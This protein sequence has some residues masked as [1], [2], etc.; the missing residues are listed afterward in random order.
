MD[1]QGRGMEQKYCPSPGYY[2]EN[3][4]LECPQ[5]C[6]DGYSD[7]LEG[8]CLACKPGLIG[9][10][11][12]ECAAGLYGN[13][14]SKNC[15]LGCGIP[16]VCHK[17]TGHCN[18][19]CLAGW[20]GDMCEDECSVGFYGVNCLQNCS[21]T[22]GIPGN[23]DRITGYCNGGCQRGSTGVRCEEGKG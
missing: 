21:M 15:S 14:C 12:M 10:R 5:N 7:S 9:L 19:S 2:E 4:S 13:N 16:G 17:D 11:C 1:R 8:T 20:E 22:C 3:C 18:E 6:Q 23:C